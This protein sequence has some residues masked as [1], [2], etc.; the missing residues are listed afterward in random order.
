MQFTDVPSGSTFYS[1]IRCLACRG[2]VGGYPCGGPSEP[3]PGP[4]FRPNNQVTRGQ[5]N[6]IVSASADFSDP[7]PIILDK[8]ESID[9]ARLLEDAPG[10]PV[11][12]SGP[13]P[14]AE[15][16]IG[17]RQAVFRHRLP[18]NVLALLIEHAGLFRP[19]SGIGRRAVGGWSG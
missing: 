12:L 3:C 8:G 15:V 7:A 18:I 13:A 4:Y 9:I 11:I 14:I 6:K 10:P 2:I 1:Y 17:V 5:V 16:E 19:G